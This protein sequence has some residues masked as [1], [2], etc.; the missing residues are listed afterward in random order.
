MTCSNKTTEIVPYKMSCEWVES[1]NWADFLGIAA[2]SN[3]IDVTGLIKIILEHAEVSRRLVSSWDVKTISNYH[4]SWWTEWNVDCQN[5]PKSFPT[6]IFHV[7]YGSEILQPN[8][9][10]SRGGSS[11]S[12]DNTSNRFQKTRRYCISEPRTVAHDA[13]TNDTVNT[14]QLPRT[15]F[16]VCLNCAE[17]R[18]STQ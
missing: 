7:K 14:Q 10:L 11:C 15:Y 16:S 1:K 18:D 4:D 9:Y 5:F 3:M 12:G 2:T 13:H 8:C 17:V 6:G